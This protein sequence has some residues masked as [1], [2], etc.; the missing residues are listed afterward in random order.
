MSELRDRLMYSQKNGYD[1]LSDGDY[2]RIMKCGERYKKFLDGS[3]TERDAVRYAVELAEKAGF[4]PY[5]EGMKLS[6]GDKIYTVNR[7]KSVILAIIGSKSL[8]SGLNIIASHIDVP[9]LDLKPLPLYEE[10]RELAYLKTHYYGGIKKYQWTAIP[11][12]LKGVVARKDGSVVNIEIGTRPDDPVFTITDLL[13]HLGKDQG[14]KTLD[15][16][17]AGEDLNV[18]VG[19]IPSRSETDGSDRTKLH[20]LEYLNEHYG[21]TEEDFTSAELSIVPV[22]PARDIGFDRSLIGGYGHDDRVCAYGSLEALLYTSSCERTAVCI[23][24]DKEEIGSVGS[25]GMKSR[26]FEEFIE[27]LCNGEGGVT[28]CQCLGASYCLSADVSA[29]FDSIY[30]GV[31][32]AKNSAYVNYGLSIVKYV[33]ARGK[34]GSNDANAEYLAYL[35]RIFDEAGVVWH[36]CELGKVDQGGGG[37]VAGYLAERGIET[38]DVG[39]PVLSMHS[40]FEVIGKHDL[41]M[42]ARACAAFFGAKEEE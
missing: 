9:R 1:R 19:S 27:S 18:L 16:G 15:E 6:A 28:T 38:V 41:Y 26:F 7:G 10:K 17:I 8:K 33:G 5:S 3:R 13:P 39:V 42:F 30:A 32:D 36:T 21:I 23:L 40:P 12:A 14:K 29:A 34:S 2:E 25:T 35:R 4:R 37:T 31:Y 20:I 22:T 24:A 11:L